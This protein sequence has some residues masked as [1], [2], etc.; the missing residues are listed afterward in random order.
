MVSVYINKNGSVTNPFLNTKK[1]PTCENEF[2]LQCGYDA[3]IGLTCEENMK[4]LVNQQQQ[5]QDDTILVLQ[6]KLENR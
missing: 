2:C 5:T 3:H 6:W 1:S 4:Q